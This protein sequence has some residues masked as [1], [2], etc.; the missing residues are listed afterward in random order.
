MRVQDGLNA[1]RPPKNALVFRGSGQKSLGLPG[2]ELVESIVERSAA[3]PIEGAGDIDAALQYGNHLRSKPYP[4]AQKHRPHCLR[5][6]GV[7]VALRQV[8]VE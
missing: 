8:A 2:V 1:C 3:V 6:I 5:M 7:T 4:F